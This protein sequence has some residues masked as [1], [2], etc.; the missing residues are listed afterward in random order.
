MSFFDKW[1]RLIYVTHQSGCARTLTQV[2]GWTGEIMVWLHLLKTRVNAAAVGLS[3]QLEVWR[4]NTN[5]PQVCWFKLII[6][7]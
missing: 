1:L 2:F 3:P 6:K 7:D 5:S 4:P